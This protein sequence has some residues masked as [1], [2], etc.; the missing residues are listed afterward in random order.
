MTRSQLVSELEQARADLIEIEQSSKF[1][2]EYKER[3]TALLTA[4]IVNRELEIVEYDRLTNQQ[5]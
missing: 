1:S 3:Q 5:L 2:M 4:F